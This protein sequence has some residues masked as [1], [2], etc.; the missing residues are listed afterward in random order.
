MIVKH[1]L[2][3]SILFPK[4]IC[5]TSIK[6]L[7]HL[8]C[9]RPIVM[10][11]NVKGIEVGSWVPWE[12]RRRAFQRAGVLGLSNTGYN[13]TFTDQAKKIFS[14]F[15]QF[16]PVLHHPLPFAL[17]GRTFSSHWSHHPRI[18]SD[19]TLPKYE[20]KL[21]LNMKQE[22]TRNW[23]SQKTFQRACIMY[24]HMYVYTHL[25]SGVGF[26]YLHWRNSP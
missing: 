8:M 17:V 4:A 10:L 1:S 7:L 9:P 21:Y 6:Y 15:W 5:E 26:F 22:K 23:V 24:V 16:L 18:S 25:I 11:C 3:K 2:T 12:R 14:L 19:K 13:M 20:T